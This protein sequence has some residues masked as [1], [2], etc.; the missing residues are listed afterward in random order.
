MAAHGNKASTD[1]CREIANEAA[2]TSKVGLRS[3]CDNRA[4]EHEFK[5]YVVRTLGDEGEAIV[6]YTGHPI[7]TRHDRWHPQ[8]RSEPAA[9]GHADEL[10]VG[11]LPDEADSDYQSAGANVGLLISHETDVEQIN[12]MALK[13]GISRKYSAGM[14]AGP[15]LPG[16][17]RREEL[18]G[19]A[20]RRC[21]GM[22][23]PA[24]R[25]ATS[26]FGAPS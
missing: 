11:K 14:L 22:Q 6:G 20:E 16:R 17:R 19:G 25:T 4:A 9:R 12:A 2:S 3:P 8:S 23:P 18:T 26:R 24:R 5:E 21:R 7:G 15:G 1:V 13:S 10:C